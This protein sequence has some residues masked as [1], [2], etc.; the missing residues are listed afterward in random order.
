MAK[1]HS[2]AVTGPPSDEDG[3]SVP[4]EPVFHLVTM[5]GG[6]QPPKPQPPPSIQPQQAPATRT[7]GSPH[8]LYKIV[9]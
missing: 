1:A 4:G 3:E 8:D 2:F 5:K 7:V 6:R 9:R